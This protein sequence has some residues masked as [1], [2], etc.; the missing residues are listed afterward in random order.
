MKIGLTVPRT[1]KKTFRNERS[2]QTIS[3][4][5]A[6]NTAVMVASFLY[7]ATSKLI[8][9]VPIVQ[10]S[11]PK[12]KMAFVFKPLTCSTPDS[13]SVHLY[14]KFSLIKAATEQRKN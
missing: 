2:N 3:Y 10:S 1:D 13:P 4:K 7:R 6:L 8:R 9:M 5:C 14:H 12:L 11:S